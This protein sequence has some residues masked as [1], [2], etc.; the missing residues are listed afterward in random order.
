[1]AYQIDRYNNTLLTVVED[2]T[3][4]RTTDLKFIGK[5]YAGYGEIQNENFLFLLENFSGATP[6][7]RAISGQ[8]WFDNSQ[9]KL[10]LYNGTQ[11][12]TI[13]GA[14][15]SDSEPSG[16]STGDFWWDSG[17]DQLYA[18]NGTNFVL[19]GP[20]SAGSG[21]TQM[22]SLVVKDLAGNDK[23]IIAATINTAD[24][25]FVIST[26]DFTLNSS[27]P[28]TG[29]D[30]IRQGIT[31][32]NT[33]N[34]TNGI[35]SSNHRFW[36]TASNAERLN[37][38]TADDF[39][40]QANPDFINQITTSDSGI[41]IGAGLDL[42]IYIQ[43][44]DEGVIENATGSSSEIIFKVTDQSGTIVSVFTITHEGIIPIT[45]N[46]I[47]LGSV[48]NTFNNVYATNFVGEASRASTLQVGSQ[49]FTGSLAKT[50]NTIA[51]R[52]A[53]GD[54]YAET[55]VGVSIQAFEADLA[56]KY[57]CDESIPCGSVVYICSDLEHDI[58]MT[59]E[60]TDYP[61]GIVST[62]PAVIMN[63]DSSGLP[64]A[65]CGR[66][67]VRVVGSV[68]KGDRVYSCGNGLAS[69]DNTL[70]FMVGIALETNSQETEKLV[71]CAVNI[72]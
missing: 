55:F 42:N 13:G 17:N 9:Q 26:D 21:I 68:S 56:E 71:E 6:P 46:Q 52:D 41:S 15:V 69:S 25:I 36:G 31:L 48:S 43:N 5:N 23:Y 72:R 8:A 61:M 20:Q 50:P 51:S 53:S 34:I 70:P 54:L 67:P 19:V 2:G 45:N 58:C 64:I 32:V 10:K 60:T 28:I 37:G 47:D 65:L 11:W 29:F 33:T 27:T 59:S 63:K 40:T 16:L 24:V 4:D 49:Y 7:P 1:M 62:K 38:A 66:V 14:E 44:N 22:R 12:K 18:Y 35:T 57:S 30:R 3:I 39:V